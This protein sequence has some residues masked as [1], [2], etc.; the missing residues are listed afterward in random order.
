MAKWVT[1]YWDLLSGIHDYV[2]HDNKEIATEYFKRH[3]KYYFQ[4]A[5]N[6]KVELPCSYGYPMRKYVGMS[7]M[8]YN[9]EFGSKESK[10]LDLPE[11]PFE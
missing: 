9:K 11:E 5:T 6:F 10:E 1:F 2:E 3:Y 4:L 8:K 7:K